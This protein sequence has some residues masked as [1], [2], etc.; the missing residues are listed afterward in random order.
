MKGRYWSLEENHDQLTKSHKSLNKSHLKLKNNFEELQK[1]HDKLSKKNKQLGK[2]LG[3]MEKNVHKEFWKVHDRL[4]YLVEKQET[5]GKL[6]NIEEHSDGVRIFKP[7][8]DFLNNT[9]DNSDDEGM[10]VIKLEP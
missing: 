8:G 5:F 7:K 4:E 10:G 3:Q 2:N 1:K 6:F 9:K